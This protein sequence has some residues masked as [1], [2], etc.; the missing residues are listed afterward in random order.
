[1]GGLVMH[2]LVQMLERNFGTFH[3]GSLGSE[4]PPSR[5][6]SLEAVRA[7]TTLLKACRLLNEFSFVSLSPAGALHL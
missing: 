7:A 6:N 1:M 2:F 3:C 5:L 4:P